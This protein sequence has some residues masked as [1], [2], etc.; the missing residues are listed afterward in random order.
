MFRRTLNLCVKKKQNRYT[1]KSPSSSRQNGGF[2]MLSVL[3]ELEPFT[4]FATAKILR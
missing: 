4:H 2:K 1:V 3:D